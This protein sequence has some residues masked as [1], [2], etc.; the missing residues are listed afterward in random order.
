MFSGEE[1]VIL[2]AMALR[3]DD[4]NWLS[5]GLGGTGQG[6][7]NPIDGLTEHIYGAEKILQQEYSMNHS[8]V[9]VKP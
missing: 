2:L 1:G 7:C 9:G 6:F 4:D 3:D 5:V 8:H